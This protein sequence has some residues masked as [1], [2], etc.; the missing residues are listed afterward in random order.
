MEKVFALVV[1]LFMLL[2]VPVCAEKPEPSE[3]LANLFT[4]V[5]AIEDAVGEGAWPRALKS[6]EE[7]EEILTGLAPSIRNAAG[8]KV[9]LGLE[10][11][12]TQLQ[13]A[14]RRRDK[15]AVMNQLISM[16]KNI[17]HTMQAY[18][19]Y[20][21]PAFLVIQRYVVEAVE[22][23][24][25]KDFG[26]VVHEMKEIANIITSSAEVMLSK[27]IGRGMQSDFRELLY[28]VLN[29]AKEKNQQESINCLKKMETTA[30]AFVWLG[31]QH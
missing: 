19:Y 18:N 17:F 27:N 11:D 7:V 4:N 20:V 12:I 8:G 28:S 2:V 24:E 9:Y 25:K 5:V 15:M 10:E 6:T 13:T 16:Q 1:T 21:H 14:I 3:E 22:A 23:A 30:G 31:S 26:R 29:A